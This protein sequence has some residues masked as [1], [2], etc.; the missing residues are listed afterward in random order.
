MLL[1]FINLWYFFAA[2]I[3]IKLCGTGKPT[4]MRKYISEKLSHPTY[5]LFLNSILKYEHF[6]GFVTLKEEETK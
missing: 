4:K 3:I 2:I 6:L 1:R 5:Q